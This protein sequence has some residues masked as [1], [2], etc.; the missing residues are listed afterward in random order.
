LIPP[1]APKIADIRDA[2]PIN[3]L[4]YN[5]DKRIRGPTFCQVINK[6]KLDHLR[7][8]LTEGNQK[9]KGAEA[10]F[11]SRAIEKI[12]FIIFLN[13]GK[14]MLIFTFKNNK[15]ELDRIKIEDRAW[16]KKYLI[17]ASVDILFEEYIRGIKAIIFTSNPNHIENQE[18]E[19]TIIS[20][21]INKSK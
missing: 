3:M 1:K 10:N 19:E 2:I 21:P 15:R 14:E 8:S 7:A 9:W 16:T 12:I 20:V 11:V 6:L 18:E 5:K 4:E 13:I 17:I